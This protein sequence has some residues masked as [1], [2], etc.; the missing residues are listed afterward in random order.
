[1]V[2]VAPTLINTFLESYDF[3]SKTVVL[4]ATSGSSGFGDTISGLENSCPEAK[5]VTTKVNGS[6]DEL[7]AFTF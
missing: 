7:A 5:I 6:V 1:M 4:F 2:Y 3:T